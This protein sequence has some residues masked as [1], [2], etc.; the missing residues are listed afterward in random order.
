[1]ALDTGLCLWLERALDLDLVVFGRTAEGVIAFK[2]GTHFFH[3][4]FPRLPVY[5]AVNSPYVHNE[6]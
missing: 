4:P 2:L 6:F 3:Q 5:G 1:M